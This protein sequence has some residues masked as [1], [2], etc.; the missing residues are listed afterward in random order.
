MKIICFPFIQFFFFFSSSHL[1][2]SA[3]DFERYRS[4]A[5]IEV[6]LFVIRARITI[7]LHSQ[8]HQESL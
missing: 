1:P 2:F 4:K 3:C 7:I 6:V 5:L 8:S